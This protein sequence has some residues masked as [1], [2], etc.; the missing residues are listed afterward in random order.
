MQRSGLHDSFGALQIQAELDEGLVSNDLIPCLQIIEASWK[1]I[2]DVFLA[3]VTKPC[4]LLFQQL[5]GY[6][7]GHKL[8]LADTTCQQLASL[9]NLISLALFP[10]QIANAQM[11]V[12]EGRRHASALCT[13]PCTCASKHEDDGRTEDSQTSSTDASA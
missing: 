9:S 1:T 4:H 13:L 2:D 8:A 10:E 7:A 3:L 6:L 5:Y 12:P 11:R